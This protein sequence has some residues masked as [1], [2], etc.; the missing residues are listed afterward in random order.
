VEYVIDWQA[1]VATGI[2]KTAAGAAEIGW[3]MLRDGFGG[4][5]APIFKVMSDDGR[6]WIFAFDG[7][8]K[9]VPDMAN[10]PKPTAKAGRRS[11]AGD[12]SVSWSTVITDA[13]SAQ[14]AANQGAALVDDALSGGPMNI[15]VVEDPSGLKTP[16]EIY[17][18]KARRAG[19]SYR[20]R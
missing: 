5:G 3:E 9:G 8:R 15:I 10:G 7:G 18:G 14:D 13:S 2:A 16:F 6:S 19:A 12:Y 4:G 11:T 20:E 17:D 1:L